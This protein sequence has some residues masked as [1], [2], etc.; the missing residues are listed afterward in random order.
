M[1]S[2]TVFKKYRIVTVVLCAAV[3]IAGSILIFAKTQ[4]RTALSPQPA[5]TPD[6][7]AQSGTAQPKIAWSQKSFDITLSP[8]ETLSKEVMFTSTLPLTNV[9]IESVP[10]IAPFLSIEP[11]TLNSALPNQTQS[12]SLKFSIPLT[13]ALGTYDGT[14]Q[15]R[16]GSQVLP[17]TLKVIIH[18]LYRTFSD[19][20]LGFTFQYPQSLFAITSADSP[21]AVFIQ[22]SNK[23]ILLG[24]GA[25]PV[26]KSPDDYTTDGYVITLSSTIYPKAFSVDQWLKDFHP[27]SELD[28]VSMTTVAGLP[29][30]KVTLK[31]EILAGSPVV[32]F[33]NNGKL[34][35]I[36][37]SS[38]FEPNS[39]EEQNGLAAFETV[40]ATF[41]FQ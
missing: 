9:S 25:I 2:L 16:S 3:V 34:Y 10:A 37:Y 39:N 11:R 1:S 15:I 14:V 23:E 26:D 28:T 27:Y 8:G 41:H 33:T 6:I 17:Q 29:A 13:T 20:T 19:E 5:L 36:S 4:F 22:N 21:G 31:G 18:V 12:V 32:L 24:G 30:F 38:T 7:T 35:G 40:L